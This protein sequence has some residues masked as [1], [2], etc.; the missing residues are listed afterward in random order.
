MY[1]YG[2]MHAYGYTGTMYVYGFIK[3]NINKLLKLISNC[4]CEKKQTAH[5]KIAFFYHFINIILV[6]HQLSLKYNFH[7]VLALTQIL[8]DKF[9]ASK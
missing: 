3:G 9:N 8:L 1:A 4:L 7:F 6:I 2:Y 5:I